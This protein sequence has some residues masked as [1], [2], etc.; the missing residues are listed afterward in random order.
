MSNMSK[1]QL[2]T[3]NFQELV[4]KTLVLR[5]RFRAQSTDFDKRDRVLDLVEEVGEL[6]HAILMVEGR[7]QVN[8]ESKQAQIED[9]AD[10]LAD[11]LFDMV[12]LA[13]DYGIE[14]EREYGEMLVRLEERINEGE[15][16]KK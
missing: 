15:F 6:A 2:K 4:R 13:E 14:L 9:V 3:H 12:V 16:D 10:A 8:V 11:I 5:D 7:K 1:P